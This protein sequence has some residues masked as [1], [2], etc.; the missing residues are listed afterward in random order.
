M[1]I[2]LYAPGDVTGKWNR[3]IPWELDNV[4]RFIKDLYRTLRTGWM[5]N[6]IILWH[7]K[8]SGDL[9][10]AMTVKD[11]QGMCLHPSHEETVI[12]VKVDIRVEIVGKVLVYIRRAIEERGN[13]KRVAGGTR[14]AFHGLVDKLLF[15]HYGEKW[16]FDEILAR[17]AICRGVI[18]KHSNNLGLIY[19]GREIKVFRESDRSS[20]VAE[21]HCTLH[22]SLHRITHLLRHL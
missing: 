20:E 10:R 22:P 8:R 3:Q 17:W 7:K 12:W 16:G 21:N 18:K 1:R 2:I 19:E 15:Q 4:P 6:R 9:N 11:F 5:K 14:E 13:K